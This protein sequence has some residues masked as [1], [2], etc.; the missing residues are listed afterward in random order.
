M[1][2]DKLHTK[3]QQAQISIFRNLLQLTN[4]VAIRF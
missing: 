3:H 1:L 2:N 4:S